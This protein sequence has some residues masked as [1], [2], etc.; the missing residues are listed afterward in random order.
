LNK[1]TYKNDLIMVLQDSQRAFK[2]VRSILEV[3]V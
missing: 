1:L 3:L 2:V